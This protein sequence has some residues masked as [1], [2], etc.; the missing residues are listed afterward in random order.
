MNNNPPRSARID[1][2]FPPEG[3]RLGWLDFS[4]E[5][6][7]FVLVQVGQIALIFADGDP[8]QVRDERGRWE[9]CRFFGQYLIGADRRTISPQAGWRVRA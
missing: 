4:Q 1:R 7:A 9:T 6:D 2:G 5:F 3:L 8:V